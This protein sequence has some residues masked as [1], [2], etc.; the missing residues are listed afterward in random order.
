MRDSKSEERRVGRV[1]CVGPERSWEPTA[2]FL[3]RRK[4]SC[5]YDQAQLPLWPVAPSCGPLSSLYSFGGSASPS[6]V[7]P[8]LPNLTC[9]RSHP[10]HPFARLHYALLLSPTLRSSPLIPYNSLVFSLPPKNLN[11][12]QNHTFFL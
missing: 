4:V 7:G 9:L 1:M 2:R 3:M 6:A 10:L 11:K 12:I 8:V 5:G